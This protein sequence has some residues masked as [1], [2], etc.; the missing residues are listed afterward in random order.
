MVLIAH[1]IQGVGEIIG[2]GNYLCSIIENPINLQTQPRK[3][4]GFQTTGSKN[5]DPVYGRVGHLGL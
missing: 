5:D 1:R 3:N 4:F 2:E